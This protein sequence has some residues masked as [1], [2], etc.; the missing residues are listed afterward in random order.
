MGLNMRKPTRNSNNRKENKPT[1][2]L[3]LFTFKK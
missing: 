3:V 1:E 2:K